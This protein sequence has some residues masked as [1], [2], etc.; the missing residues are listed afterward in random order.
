[1]VRCRGLDLAEEEVQAHVAAGMQVMR[2][3]LNWHDRVVFTV[4]S[5]L[6]IRGLQFL[7]EV[8]DQ[9]HDVAA[10]TD[11]ERFDA[12]FTIMSHELAQLVPDL[13]EGFG[14]QRP[15]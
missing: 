2:L 6:S 12:D 7:D 14:I 5:E 3:A 10:E 1:M 8:R 4:D 11:A 15:A 9:L 13:L